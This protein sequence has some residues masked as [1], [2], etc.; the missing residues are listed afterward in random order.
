[1]TREKAINFF[2]WISTLYPEKTAQ[3]AIRMA[4]KALEAPEL[5]ARQCEYWDSES[6]YCALNRPSAQ[7]DLIAQMQKNRMA[8]ISFE[9]VRPMPLHVF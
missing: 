8:Y 4:I 9:P 7:S 2:E 5:S 3:T 1:M 6:N